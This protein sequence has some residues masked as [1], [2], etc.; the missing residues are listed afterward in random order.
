[1]VVVQDLFGAGQ[2]LR[3]PGGLL[4][5]HAHE[6][7][8]VVA[9][10]RGLGRDRGHRLEPAQLLLGLLPDLLGHPGGLD[11]LL[12]LL[13]LV[14]PVVLAPELLMDGLD[15]LVEVV[16]LLGL[17]HL[18]LDLVVDPAVDVDLVDLDLQQVLELLKTLVGRLGL[19]Q[20]LLLG[21]GDRE[22]R[23]QGVGEPLR[24]V[25]LER[26]REALEGQVVRQ[27][28]V[29]LEER[30]DL[31]HV[32]LE[33]LGVDRPRGKDLDGDGEVGPAP[34]EGHDAAPAHALDHHLDVTVRELQGLGDGGDDADLVD[35][36]GR[37]FVE[38]RVALRREEEPLDRRRERGLE[39]ADRGLAAHDEGL[40]HVGEDDHVPER[41]ERQ[42]FQPAAAAIGFHLGTTNLSG[43]TAPSGVS[44]P[45][46]AGW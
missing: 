7:L 3:L 28:R 11:L 32:V 17:L 33:A 42:A 19:E 5:G 46:C 12:E 26:G 45:P 37:R 36:L 30:E 4:P 39:R 44:I 9:R 25:D 13:D 22:V 6:P 18:L 10:D 43:G 21:G 1:M 20:R 40:H 27:L 16:L 23:R 31:A 8:D 24:V 34:L 41:D 29:L 35:V 14:R 2:V 15:L 38:L